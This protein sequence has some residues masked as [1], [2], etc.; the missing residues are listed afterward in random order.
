MFAVLLALPLLYAGR[1]IAKSV[2]LSPNTGLAIVVGLIAAA[3]CLWIILR[4]K[5]DKS[6]LRRIFVAALLLRWIVGSVI[7]FRGWQPFFGADAD[8]YDAFGNALCQSWLGMVDP[9]APWL[10]SYTSSQR[11]GFGMFYYV[12]SVYYLIDQNP[13]A[14]QLINCALGASLCVVAYKIAML[15][16][17]GQRVARTAAVLT[18]FSPSMILWSSQGL[19]DGPIALFIALCTL[20]TIRLRDRLNGKEFLLLL[21]SLFCLFALRNYAAYMIFIAMAATFVLAARRFTPLRIGQGA[22]LVILIGLALSYF[23]SDHV[24]QFAESTLDLKHIQAIRVWGARVATSGYGA[25]V[26]ISDPRAALGFLPVGLVYV[27]FAPFPWM[28]VNLRQLITLPEMI[29]WWLLVPILLK[30]YS[31]CL[32]HRLRESF[33]ITI[34]S[35][36]LTMA[37]ALY[38]SNVGTAYRQRAQL[39][40]FFFIF[41]S[42]GLELKRV[43]R[44][45]K[46][47]RTRVRLAVSST[48]RAPFQEPSINQLN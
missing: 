36:G 48:A 27:L 42:I 5:T 29:A 16:Y 13:L 35:I 28:M 41:I 43:A 8:T 45:R 38:Q 26:D 22:I 4:V 12:A 30:G 37:Y 11:P 20:F 14:I 40:V 23:A 44:E 33:P 18:A 15:I 31:F 46:R 1:S 34:F 21:G 6:F 19:K 2:L 39:F 3:A 24:Q 47:T 32:R 17:P 9:N 7:Y 25:D 10:V